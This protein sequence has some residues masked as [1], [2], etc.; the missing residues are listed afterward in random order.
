MRQCLKSPMK[1]RK[2]TELVQSTRAKKNTQT[3]RPTDLLSILMK[4]SRQHFYK[5]CRFKWFCIDF[6][7]FT[8]SISEFGNFRNDSR[9]VGRKR[10][11]I[12]IHEKMYELREP[13]MLDPDPVNTVVVPYQFCILV[14]KRISR[15]YYRA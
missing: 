1:G 10:I 11:G 5:K 7:F 14:V 15:L 4:T 9:L 12:R 2:R 8:Y 6:Q 13:K 3:N